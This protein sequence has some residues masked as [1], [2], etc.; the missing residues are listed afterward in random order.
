M[1]WGMFGETVVPFLALLLGCLMRA[2]V[3]YLLLAFAAI[4]GEES[5]FSDWPA[6]KPMYVSVF[7]L[8]VVLYAVALLTIPGAA[9]W[10]I[11]ESFIAVVAFGYGGGSFA[12]ALAKA[13]VRRRQ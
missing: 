9:E 7:G 3:P 6:F 13:F 11:S 1:N 2:L 12:N 8:A 5:K 4:G 10:L